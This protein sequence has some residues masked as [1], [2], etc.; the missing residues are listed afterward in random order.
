MNDRTPIFQSKYDHFTKSYLT[1]DF[2][3][4]KYFRWVNESISYV[5][6]DCPD[7]NSLNSF[8]AIDEFL[9]SKG[10]SAPRIIEID[11]ENGFLLLEDFGDKTFTM[12]LQSNPKA[13][14]KL[15]KNATDVLIR[16]HERCDA[17]PVIL[18]E[19]TPQ[20]ALN[21]VKLFTEY[22][23][24]AISKKNNEQ[25]NSIFQDIWQKPIELA[26]S[27]K[28]SVFLRDYHVDNLMDLK[29]RKPP[30]NVGLLDFQDALWAPVAGDLVSLLYD[31]RRDVDEEVKQ[32]M[33]KLYLSAYS[34]GEHEEIY[35][36]GIILSAIRHAKIIG[37]FTRVAVTHKNTRFLNRI[38][39]L[40]KMLIECCKIEEMKEVREWFSN[41][42]PEPMRIVPNLP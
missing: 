21:K 36:A 2:S 11:L 37:I 20:I 32:E 16:L 1:A 10:F 6:M 29:T 23:L 31:A 27:S 9:V 34:K 14:Y 13:E 26:L 12:V 39:S 35:I 8:V 30:Q 5:L 15:Y 38:P 18:P 17:K 28:K 3:P 40:W 33:W 4:R 25:I 24:P 42:V 41:H 19:Y 22:Y 7:L